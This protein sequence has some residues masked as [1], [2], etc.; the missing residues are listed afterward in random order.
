MKNIAMRITYVGTNYHGWQYQENG[1]TVQEAVETAIRK[2][3]GAP[4]RVTGCSR[5]DAGVHALDYVLNFRSDTKIPLERLPYALNYHLGGDIT[6]IEA[7]E[8]EPEFNARFSARGKRY[9]YNIWNHVF[10]NPFMAGYSWHFPYKLD[11]ERMK[12][13]AAAFVGT[14]DFKGFMASGGQQK[15]TVRTIRVCTAERDEN[16]PELIKITVEA[17]A[18]LYNMVRIIA[19]TLAD[20]GTGR[21]EPEAMA[22]IIGGG[23][24]RLGGITAPPQGLFLKKVYFD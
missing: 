10:K 11:V 5:T 2:T 20:V 13:A 7:W 14:H 21:L 6:A 17:D 3:T 8:A 1:I 4:V 16:T 9:V 19:G 18:F 23:D 24:R 12:K 22:D 15:T